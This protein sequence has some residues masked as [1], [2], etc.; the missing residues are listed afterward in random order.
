MRAS[1]LSLRAALAI[2]LFLSSHGAAAQSGGSPS[3]VGA[4]RIR[5]VLTEHPEWTVYWS[6]LGAAPRPPASAGTGTVRFTRHGDTIMAHIEIPAMARTCEVEIPIRESGFGYP[7]CLSPQDRL[8][9]PPDREIM[10]DPDDRNYPFK[11]TG[12]STWYWFQP[13]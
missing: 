2:V 4:D 7:G 12:A 3:T 11:G 13:K 1:A 10:F 8:V 6:S 5:A 9:R